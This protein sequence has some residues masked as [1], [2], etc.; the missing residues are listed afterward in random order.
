MLDTSPCVC[1]LGCKVF[2]EV[3]QLLSAE[4]ILLKWDLPVATS[5]AALS[6]SD[7]VTAEFK[8]RVSGACS[9]DEP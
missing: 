1:E 8:F 7:S 5:N 3:M 9:T 2:S 6:L 4:A